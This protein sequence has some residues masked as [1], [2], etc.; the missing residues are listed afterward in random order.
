MSSYKRA[1]SS[2]RR[3]NQPRI[4]HMTEY[5]MT[6]SDSDGRAYNIPTVERRSGRL[7]EP[8]RAIKRAKQQGLLGFGYSSIDEAVKAAA[9]RS[10]DKFKDSLTNENKAPQ[11]TGGRIQRYGGRQI[12]MNIPYNPG[13]KKPQGGGGR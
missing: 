9:K 10:K 5:T 4:E 1:D 12:H 2:P 11:V 8:D 6:I 13:G 3:G 7:L